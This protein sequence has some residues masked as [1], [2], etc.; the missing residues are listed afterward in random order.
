[1]TATIDKTVVIDVIMP[2]FKSVLNELNMKMVM[3]ISS[4]PPLIL[5]PVKN[6]TNS[7]FLTCLLSF[8]VL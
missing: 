3:R 6:S 8:I 1:M 7:I 4:A 2:K 5:M